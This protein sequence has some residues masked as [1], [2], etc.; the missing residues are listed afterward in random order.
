M[1]PEVDKKAQVTKTPAGPFPA[2]SSP[3]Q[4]D[5]PEQETPKQIHPFELDSGNNLLK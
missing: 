1:V 2:T 4:F 3:S 5:G